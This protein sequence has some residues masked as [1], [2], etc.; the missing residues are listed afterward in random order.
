MGTALRGRFA[1]GKKARADALYPPKS[2]GNSHFLEGVFLGVSARSEMRKRWNFR[3]F[4]AALGSVPG[5]QYNQYL[6]IYSCEFTL[7][8]LRRQLTPRSAIRIPSLGRSSNPARMTKNLSRKCLIVFDCIFQPKCTGWH[9]WGYRT[10]GRT[11][12]PTADTPR[13]YG[14]T[15]R[16]R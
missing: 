3:R 11:N 9:F 1:A 7:P 10:D 16:S 14:R 12:T 8:L 6:K 5:R 13:C 4:I 2:S 15:Q